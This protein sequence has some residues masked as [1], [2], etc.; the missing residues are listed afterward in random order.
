MPNGRGERSPITRNPRVQAEYLQ[1]VVVASLSDLV[2]KGPLAIAE[3]EATQVPPALTT[4]IP[5]TG[6]TRTASYMTQT[7]LT[8]GGAKPPHPYNEG[9]PRVALAGLGTHFLQIRNAPFGSPTVWPLGHVL[10]QLALNR[11]DAVPV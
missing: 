4:A 9:V 6:T 10:E 11:L 1:L 5:D 8:E 2:A 7:P 3:A